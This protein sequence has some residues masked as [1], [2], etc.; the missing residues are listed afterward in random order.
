[1]NKSAFLRGI[2]AGFVCFIV[3]SVY[4]GYSI[5]IQ[6]YYGPIDFVFWIPV[7]ISHLIASVFTGFAFYRNSNRLIIA[8]ITVSI[9]VFLLS[10][11]YV[12]LPIRILLNTGQ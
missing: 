5:L 3:L 9:L 7:F 10:V 11:I 8:S 12:V 6:L 2:V 4:F 1:M